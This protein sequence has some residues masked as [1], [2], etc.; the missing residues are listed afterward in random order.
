MVKVVARNLVKKDKV[1]AFIELAKELVEETRKEEG[2]IKY[3]LFQDEVGI[4]K[5][6]RANLT[7]EEGS[8]FCN[9]GRSPM[10]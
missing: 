7:L 5:S 9:T 8:K 1:D 4:R 2:C 6:T 10:P 3:E